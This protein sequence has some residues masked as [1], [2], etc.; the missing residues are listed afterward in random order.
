MTTFLRQQSVVVSPHGSK[1]R[2]FACEEILEVVPTIGSRRPAPYLLV[3]VQL[4]YDS[5]GGSIIF[6]LSLLFLFVS[7]VVAEVL[8]KLTPSTLLIV[9]LQ[10]IVSVLLR[11]SRYHNSVQ[12]RLLKLSNRL[13]GIIAA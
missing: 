4:Y 8:E 7:T 6:F 13:L 2:L 12:D 5:A 10:N 11:L 3:T 1:W 9:P